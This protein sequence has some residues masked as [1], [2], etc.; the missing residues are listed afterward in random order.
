MKKVLWLKF[1]MIV[2]RIKFLVLGYQSLGFNPR[3]GKC[4][5]HVPFRR[6]NVIVLQALLS[7]SHY[8][9][10][11]PLTPDPFEVGAEKV[12]NLTHPIDYLIDLVKVFLLRGLEV[13][14][15]YDAAYS[16]RRQLL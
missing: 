6:R 4:V 10:A 3:K 16:M 2:T 1:Q 9:F 5:G 14:A 11:L 7:L 15:L 12:L 8:R 13:G